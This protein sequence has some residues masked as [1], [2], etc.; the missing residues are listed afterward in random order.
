M[1]SVNVYTFRSLIGDLFSAQTLTTLILSDNKLRDE[2]ARYFAS[3]L[4]V[5]KVRLLLHHS[6]TG[7]LS[8]YYLGAGSA[9]PLEQ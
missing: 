5:N 8:S 3:A 7:L 2:G 1:E 6:T 4:R 9:E